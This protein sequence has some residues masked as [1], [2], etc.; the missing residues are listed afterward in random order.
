MHKRPI[1]WWATMA[2][3][4]LA[5]AGWPLFTWS[6]ARTAEET[7]LAT[8]AKETTLLEQK[9]SAKQQAQAEFA[10]LQQEL[11]ALESQ[12][13]QAQRSGLA[14]QQAVLADAAFV[15]HFLTQVALAFSARGRIRQLML[16]CDGEVQL[17]GTTDSDVQ[18][19]G[20]L[21][22]F[23][24]AMEAYPQLKPLL[25]STI[26]DSEQAAA[27]VSSD[28]AGIDFSTPAL[29]FSAE[30]KSQISSPYFLNNRQA[31]E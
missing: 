20:A 19:Q 3:A 31:A 27:D 6:K 26:A 2:A 22:L 25:L 11:T 1:V 13:S 23:L 5:A 30:T 12:I 29:R 16:T 28:A 15:E 17:K 7:Q 10:R 24:T 4:L 14:S 8:L 18:A 21:A 9:L